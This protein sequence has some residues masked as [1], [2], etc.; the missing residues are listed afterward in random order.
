MWE[1]RCEERGSGKELEQ[2]LI[3]AGSR[4]FDPKA[5]RSFSF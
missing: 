4:L 5:Q 3:R 1:R 2:G